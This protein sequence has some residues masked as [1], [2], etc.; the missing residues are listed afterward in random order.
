MISLISATMANIVTNKAA[1]QI[2]FPIA[3]AIYKSNGKNPLPGIM[4]MCA[5][6]LMPMCTPYGIAANIL[7]VGPGGY[8][9]LDF[10]KF[11]T[12]STL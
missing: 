11:G 3:A 6:S 10:L 2:L 5:M 4:V 7:I 9:P 12:A 8:S 1:I